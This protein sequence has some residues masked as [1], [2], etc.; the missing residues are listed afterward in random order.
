MKAGKTSFAKSRCV[1]AESQYVE[2][3][4]R[5]RYQESPLG[6]NY[7]ASLPLVAHGHGA[8]AV[9]GYARRPRR[10]RRAGATMSA[11]ACSRTARRPPSQPMCSARNTTASN[12]PMATGSEPRRLKGVALATMLAASAA[13]QRDGRGLRQAA[14]TLRV[15][16]GRCA[17]WVAAGRM[18]RSPANRRPALGMLG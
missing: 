7:N 15:G 5:G 14:T 18:E 17:G 6:T 11:T 2:M 4:Q 3:K 8:D 9:R 10:G 1:T 16:A 13:Q 12:K